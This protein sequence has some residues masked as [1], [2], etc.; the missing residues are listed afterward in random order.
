MSSI[1]TISVMMPTYNVENVLGDT[2]D[3][4]LQQTFTDW[5]LIIVDDGSTDGTPQVIDEYAKKD[6]RI[7]V[8]HYEHGGR[9]KARNRCLKHSQGKYIAICDSDDI[10]FPE[11]FEKQVNFLENNPDIGVVGAQLCS[12]SERAIFDET[13]II[14]WPTNAK[15]VYDA[16]KKK[17]M[18]ISNCAA[19]IRMSVFKEYGEYCEELHR[20]QDYEFFKRII[21]KG[22]KLTN[23]PEVLVYYRQANSIPSFRYFRENAIYKNYADYVANG[24]SLSFSQ[25]NQTFMTKIHRQ[26]IRFMYLRYLFIMNTKQILLKAKIL[27]KKLGSHNQIKEGIS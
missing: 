5:E 14:Y 1:P 7:K 17:K 10:S 12:F 27:I 8:Y 2:I 23:L 6:P 20:S 15:E 18:K 13:K 4:V 11:R 19:M 25:F 16:F 22:I 9:G 21:S 3:S 26:F 24:G